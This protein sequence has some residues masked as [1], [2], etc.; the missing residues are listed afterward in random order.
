[1][2]LPPTTGRT[3]STRNRYV[4]LLRALAI[5]LVVVG[6]WL[7]TAIVPEGGVPQ[8][9]DA[10]GVVTWGSWLTLLF[11]VIPVFFLAGGFANAASWSAHRREGGGWGSWLYGRAE[12]ILRPTTVFVIVGFLAT[13]CAR[14]A[15]VSPQVLVP[16]AWGVA[17]QLWFLPVYL[18]LLA[19]TP[20]LCAWYRRQG[21]RLVVAAGALAVAVDVLVLRGGPELLGYLNYLLVWG[22]AFVLGVAWRDGVLTRTRYRPYAMACAGAVALCLLVTVGPFPL[23]MVGVPGAR[24]ANTSPPSVALLAFVLTQIGVVLALEP[25]AQR[26]LSHRTPW[27]YV[28]RTNLVIMTIY[29]WHMVPVVVVAAVVTRVP[30]MSEPAIGSPAWWLRRPLWLALLTVVLLPIVA[31]LGPFERGRG[32]SPPGITGPLAVVALL[33]GLLAAGTALGRL[34]VGGFDPSGRI[35]VDTFVVYLLG[36]ALVALS[37]RVARPRDR[38]PSGDV[39]SYP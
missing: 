23:S 5:V 7:T 24:I 19:L 9:V 34:A 30:G 21:V 16:A 35:S 6:H 4:D 33:A 26:W 25:P 2:P 12:R 8:G 18:L 29:L 14:L 13:G 27:T 1:M 36:I 22:I 37:A 17:L 31:V 39:G 11:Q 20:T 15:Q 10:L 3:G 38:D 32:P 28:V